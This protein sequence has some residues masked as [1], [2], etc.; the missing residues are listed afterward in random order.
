MVPGSALRVYFQDLEFKFFTWNFINTNLEVYAII[1]FKLKIL[2]CLNTAF[3]LSFL[4]IFTW[5]GLRLWCLMPLLTIFQLYRGGGNQST[6][7]KPLTNFI[8]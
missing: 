7:R 5:L 6:Q 8:T 3:S 2:Y 1:L 4:G